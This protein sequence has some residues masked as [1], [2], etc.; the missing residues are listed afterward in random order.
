[1]NV[2]FGGQNTEFENVQFFVELQRCFFCPELKSSWDLR[3]QCGLYTPVDKA[4]NEL[5]ISHCEINSLKLRC[6][7]QTLS[8]RE[9]TESFLI[10]SE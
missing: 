4:Y 1:M 9:N 5:C 3:I 6:S 7:M 10:E 8:T 2:C